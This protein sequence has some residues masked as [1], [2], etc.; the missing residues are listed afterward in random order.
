[1]PENPKQTGS[2]A[3]WL[4]DWAIRVLIR[5]A[6][7]L[8]LA[9]RLQFMGWFMRCILAPLTGYQKRALANLDYIYPEKPSNEKLK[10]ARG[11]ADNAGR[12]F[13]ENYDILALRKRLEKA[14]ITG[15]GF[16]A[17]LEAKDSGTPVVFVTGHYGN[18]EAPRA[19][20]VAQG[21]QI[22]GLYRPMANP[23]FNQHYAQNMHDLSGPV[24][25]QGRK[26]TL[27]LLRHIR[28][29]GMAVLLFDIYDGA[30]A[31]LTFLGKPAPTVTSVADIALKTQAVVIP[32]FGIRRADGVDFDIVFEEPIAPD[33]P[34]QMMQQ[35]TQRLEKRI[36]EDPKQWFWIHRRWKPDRQ[37]ARA[38]AK[39][40]P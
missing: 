38:A 8:P 35:I 7:T 20:L 30:G 1:M 19:A 12:T 34:M 36:E 27:G 6:R 18:F 26:G 4:T 40:V 32:F 25:E 22:G 5:S 9:M 17:A 11:A 33:A 10:I 24:F 31:P 21:F 3:E 23:Y 29:G 37:R 13:I 16:A 14:K 39:T 15:P 2:L 28:Q